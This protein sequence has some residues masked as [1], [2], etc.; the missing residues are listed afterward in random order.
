MPRPGSNAISAYG[1]GGA[2]NI[3]HPAGNAVR[4]MQMVTQGNV[5][6]G[7]SPGASRKNVTTSS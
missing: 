5:G 7:S 3:Q 6:W 2:C 1:V 4:S